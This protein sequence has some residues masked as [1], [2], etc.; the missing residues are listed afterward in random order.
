MSWKMNL[1]ELLSCKLTRVQLK[2]GEEMCY[3]SISLITRAQALPFVFTERL[4]PCTTIQRFALMFIMQPLMRSFTQSVALDEGIC[5]HVCMDACACALESLTPITSKLPCWVTQQPLPLPLTR[6][7]RALL[8]SHRVHAHT[9]T[10]T[11]TRSACSSQR[12]VCGWKSEKQLFLL[13]YQCVQA[14]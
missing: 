4:Q 12:Q 11:H 10:H 7:K 6:Q 13:M 1:T 14:V 3:C 5:P 8:L 2:G 9:R